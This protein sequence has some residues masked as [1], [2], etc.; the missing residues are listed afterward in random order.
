M[1][2]ARTAYQVESDKGTWG[3]LSEEQ[4]ILQAVQAEVKILKDA[5]LRLKTKQG[6][7]REG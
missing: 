5:N 3:A 2:R 6:G 7:R 4:Q 1:S